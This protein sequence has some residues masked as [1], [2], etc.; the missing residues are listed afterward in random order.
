MSFDQ[1]HALI[2]GVSS[3][4]FAPRL[5]VP[6]AAKD[7]NSLAP[8]LY[9]PQHCGYPRD[10]INVLTA[11]GATRAGILE[12]LD[13]LAKRTQPEDTVLIFHTGHG[14]YGSD[15]NYYLICHDSEIEGDKVVSGSGVSQKQLLE[16]CKAIPAERLLMIFNACHSGEISPA[17]GARETFGSKSLPGDTTEALLATGSGRVVITACRENQV[18]Y[19]GKGELSIFTQALVDSLQGKGVSARGGFISVFDL[20]T[21]VF[22]RVSE[23]VWDMLGDKQEPELTVLKGVGPMAVALYQGATQTNL[24][25]LEGAPKPPEGKAVRFIE[26]DQS[27]HNYQ[28]ITGQSGGIA[29]GPGSRSEVGGDMIGGNRIDTGGGAYVGGSVDTGGGDFVGRDQHITYGMS[30][31]QAARLFADIYSRIETHPRLD[32]IDKADLKTDVQEIQKE[33]VKGDSAD[34]SFLAR[35]LRNIQRTAPDILEVVLSTLTNPAAGFAAVIRKV[36]ERMKTAA[37]GGT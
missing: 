9:D 24:G 11:T 3:Y 13:Q 31:D 35:R 26:R 23:Q 15:G 8:I 21:A 34:E 25:V 27:V 18:S 37:E 7:A 16:K 1:G 22:D 36:A 5:N 10:K 2:V 19:I 12:A 20:Y 32:E 29:I 30:A 14:D 33:V 6:I 28:K 17:F 4:R